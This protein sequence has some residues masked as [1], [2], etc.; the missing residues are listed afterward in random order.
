MN[1]KNRVLIF[2]GVILALTL[3]WRCGVNAKDAN[4]TSIN[5]LSAEELLNNSNTD[6]KEAMSAAKEGFVLK[7][8]VEIIENAHYDPTAID[9]KMAKLIYEEFLEKLDYGKQVFTQQDINTFKIAVPTIDNQFKEGSTKFFDEVISKF[10]ERKVEV[11]KYYN[12]LINQN[13]TFD[14]DEIIELDGK[15]LNYA[16]NSAE[17]KERWRKS[18]KYRLLAKYVELQEMQKTKKDT[19]K[20][21]TII[22]NEKLLDSARVSV[23]RNMDMYFKNVNTTSNADLFELYAN[24][25]TNLEDPHSEFFT[26]RSKQSFDEQMSGTFYGIGATLQMKE[27]FCTITSIVTGSPC[28]KQ[29]SIKVDDKILKVAQGNDEPVDVIGWDVSDIVKLI[30]GKKDTEVRLHMKHATGVEEVVSLIRDEIKIDE[31]FAKSAIIKYNGHDYGFISLPEFYA[32]FAKAGGKRCSEDVRE[33]IMKLKAEN[34]KGII[35]DLRYNGGGSLGD[36]VEIG[37]YFL[38]KQPIVLVSTKDATPKALTPKH[39]DKI[40]D[41]PLVVMTN[42]ASASASEILAGAIQDYNRGI[43]VGGKTY[44]KGTVQRSIDIDE[45]FANSEYAP[46]GSIKL[47]L[48]KYYRVNGKSTQRMGV[49]PDILLPDLFMY[50]DGS[51]ASKKSA[52]AYDEVPKVNYNVFNNFNIQDVI[53]NYREIVK[54]DTYYK[55]I[56]TLSK[57]VK[58]MQDDQQHSLNEKK[59]QEQLKEITSF[60]KQLDLNKNVKDSLNI[61]NLQA[62]L[63]F[64]KAD[65]VSKKKNDDW[66]SF[67]NKDQQ[68]IDA[69]TILSKIK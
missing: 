45:V 36:V 8:L 27:N 33:E 38:G 41:G 25:L 21:W 32:D 4:E 10:G 60:N 7:S 58:E 62:D 46:L 31:T 29:G 56:T 20:N 59:Y 30:R 37:G 52:L 5:S 64:I 35:M 9:D 43:I 42:F 11:Q 3:S 28:F 55:N 63:K 2:V 24:S 14:T 49:N 47:T 12:E 61:F 51:E 57:K 39:D 18:I 26:P 19:V 66:M 50:V 53:K 15:K 44:G 54:K 1:N 40:W 22:S 48:Q 13:Y 69:V 34:V 17:L 65:T 16:A 23:K 67:R 68:I 6:G